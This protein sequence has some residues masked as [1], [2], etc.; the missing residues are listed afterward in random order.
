MGVFLGL[1]GSYLLGATKLAR[2]FVMAAGLGMVYTFFWFV[3]RLWK[4]VQYLAA[5][6]FPPGY[7]SEESWVRRLKESN[8]KQQLEILSL[9][10]N[11]S[12]SLSPREFLNV[13]CKVRGLI[14][15]DPALSTYW[16][17]RAD[18][19]QVLRQEA[20]G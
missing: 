9:T 10:T 3:F 13:L 6:P 5:R 8:A 19:E 15:E 11:E 16:R 18:L 12:L 1:W 2:G 14:T 17:Q 7:F 20:R 4:W